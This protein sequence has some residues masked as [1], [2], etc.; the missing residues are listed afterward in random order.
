MTPDFEAGSSLVHAPYCTSSR[1]SL[2]SLSLPLDR[3]SRR[4][5][6]IPAKQPITRLFPPSS[7]PSSTPRLSPSNLALCTTDSTRTLRRAASLLSLLPP[8]SSIRTSSTPFPSSV[9]L[10]PSFDASV[11]GLSM[12]TGLWSSGAKG[13]DADA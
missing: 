8:S 6:L 7:C 11:M 9:H 2:R 4:H 12:A 5:P 10:R 13:S 3:P 1:S